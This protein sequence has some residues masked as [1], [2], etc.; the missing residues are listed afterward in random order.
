MGTIEIVGRYY[1]DKEFKEGLEV[2][3][4]HLRSGIISV[5][6]LEKESEEVIFKCR[7]GH[8]IK[9]Y[10]IQD[11]CENV[12]LESA[13]SIDNKDDI[14]TN[15]EWCELEIVQ[16]ETGSDEW[17]ESYTWT[18]CKLKTNKG[19]DTMRWYG[20]SNGYYSEDVDIDIY[21]R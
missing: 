7:D 1:F 6:G 13:D 2:V 16:G 8:D 14:Y 19:Y 15:C 5:K 4:E 21:R 18:F 11:C 17:G 9:I 10:H 12:Y 20:T 3:N